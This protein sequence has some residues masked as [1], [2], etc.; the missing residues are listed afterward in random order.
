MTPVGWAFA[1]WGVICV[2][3]GAWVVQQFC[4][5]GRCL[6]EATVASSI[7][8]V[9]YNYLFTVLAQ[10]SWTLTFSQELIAVSAGMMVL[11]L[12]NLFVIVQSLAK[13]ETATNTRSCGSAGL[14]YLL[15]EFPFAIH[16]GWILAATV[17]NANVVL[18]A[19]NTSAAV[20]YYGGAVGGLAVLVVTALTLIWSSATGYLTAPVTVA[21]ALLGVYMELQA[22]KDTIA[23]RFSSAQLDTVQYAALAAMAVIL[24]SVVVQGIRQMRA[25]STTAATRTN[26]E[27]SVYLRAH[28]S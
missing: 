23:A 22:P 18:V 4:G 17:V 14:R 28:D 10:V 21:W 9:K 16:F 8:T 1:I 5:A 20:Q 15:L 19:E 11:I 13:L 27:E 12:W 7:A 24:G 3:Q 2:A 25:A 6:Q 26:A